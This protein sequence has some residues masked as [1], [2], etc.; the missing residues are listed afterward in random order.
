MST[1]RGAPQ[2]QGAG[3]VFFRVV[4]NARQVRHEDLAAPVSKIPPIAAPQVW[5]VR[6]IG[7]S[8]PGPGQQ[9]IA[10]TT[11]EAAQPRR[12]T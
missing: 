2:N 3:S 6:E 12:V 8:R 7:L 4:R 10:P 11:D 9:E 1:I 5:L